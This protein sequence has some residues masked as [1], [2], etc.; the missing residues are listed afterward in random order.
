LRV[1][2]LAISL[3]AKALNVREPLPQTKRLAR[4]ASGPDLNCLP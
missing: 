3:V 4:C 2:R 1:M